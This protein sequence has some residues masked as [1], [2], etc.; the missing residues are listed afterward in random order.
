MNVIAAGVL[1]VQSGKV[2]AISR[3]LDRANLTIPGGH[4]EKS[5]RNV[6]HAAARELHEETGVVVHPPRLRYLRANPSERGHYVAYFAPEI[7]SLP[8]IL[9]SIPFEGFVG[10][11]H[12][13][14]LLR[15][16]VFHRDFYRQIFK[17]IGL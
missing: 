13:Q 2:L 1:I 15:P 8:T 10:W 7:I 4:V 6:R 3:G 9:R 16:E 17:Q 14:K 12:P 11:H 5:D